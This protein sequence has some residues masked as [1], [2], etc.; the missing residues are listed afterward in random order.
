MIVRD[1]DGTEWQC[2]P[3]GGSG[4]TDARLPVGPEHH[5]VVLVECE[6]KDRTM[7]VWMP[8]EWETRPTAE[9]AKLIEDDLSAE[10]MR[11]RVSGAADEWPENVDPASYFSTD[12]PPP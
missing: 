11:D 8:R 9:L 6:S 7:R 2:R 10:R 4:K 5:D 1:S 12:T 3:T